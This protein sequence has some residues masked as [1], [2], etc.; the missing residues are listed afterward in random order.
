MAKP[1]IILKK[2][3]SVIGKSCS[4]FSPTHKENGYEN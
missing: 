1:L 2:P 3:F 4:D